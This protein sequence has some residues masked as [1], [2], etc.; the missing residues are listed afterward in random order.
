MRVFAPLCGFLFFAAPVVAAELQII[1]TGAVQ[2]VERPMAAEFGAANGHELNTIARPM[3]VVRQLVEAGEPADIIIAS[4]VV[5]ESFIA[6]GAVVEGSVVPVGRIGIGVAVREGALQPKIATVEEFRAAILAVD[7]LVHMD[8]AAGISS[9]IAISRIF[10][11][12]GIA[13]QIASKTLL[14]SSGYS[15]EQVASGKAELAIQNMTQ[16]MAVEGI[17]IVGPLPPEIQIE[18]SYVVSVAAQSAHKDVA[19]AFISY[20]TREEAEDL[21][22]EVGIE[23]G[24]P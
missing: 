1:T 6:S 24:A 10:A 20:L 7:S 14:Q 8:P 17:T 16:L 21:W 13:D 22:R 12:L 4:S 19:A 11:E 23:P 2:G 9:G 5:M 3:A 15:A 18:T